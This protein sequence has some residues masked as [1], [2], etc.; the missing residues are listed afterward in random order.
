MS[1]EKI[2][3]DCG[4]ELT[5]AH[6]NRVRCVVCAKKERHRRDRARTQ[7]RFDAITCPVCNDILN[8]ITNQ[9]I[10]LHGY[11][12]PEKF[13]SDFGLEYLKC[14][15]MRTAQSKFMS[16]NNNSMGGHSE[17]TI[18]NI[19]KGR[20]GKG[21]GVAGKYERTPEIRSKISRG[22]TKYW[23]SG[24][25]HHNGE[26]VFCEKANSCVY[27]RSSW[28]RRVI[29]VLD[30][31]EQILSVQMEPFSIPYEFEEATLN[32]IPDFLILTEGGIEELWEVKPVVLR[33]VPK[34][35][36]KLEALNE[37]VSKHENMNARIVGLDDI[38][39]M[40]RFIILQ[41]ALSL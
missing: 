28:E 39:R 18:K 11:S 32:Y 1:K 24:G 29:W 5:N 38:E 4:I 14:P 25:W 22:V 34:N 26:W 10:N 23:L 13:K 27:T 35:S 9:H 31:C 17:E 8:A 3:L 2:C 40:K 21:I 33:T 16:A 15:S 36:A 19:S 30:N 12:D 41:S 6:F 37:F 7:L 20:R